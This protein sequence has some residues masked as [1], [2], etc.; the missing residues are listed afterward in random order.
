MRKCL[1]LV[2]FGLSAHLA[3]AQNSL[4]KQLDQAVEA[5]KRYQLIDA[6][7][8]FAE[9]YAQKQLLTNIQRGELLYYYSRAQYQ[10]YVSKGN[11]QKE[12]LADYQ[13][14]RQ[15]YF[16]HQLLLELQRLD[17]PR[18]SEKAEPQLRAMSPGLYEGALIS[19][20]LLFTHAEG[21]TPSTLRSVATGYLSLAETIDPV[22]Y[23]TH[24]LYGQLYYF[25]Q[26]SASA[27]FYFDRCLE[28][29]RTHRLNEETNMRLG[30][31]FLKRSRMLFNSSLHDTALTLVNHGLKM[32]A[33]EFQFAKAQA[34]KLFTK[35][36][37]QY[38]TDLYTELK[39]PLHWLKLELLSVMPEK[40]ATAQQVFD[41]L[42]T[43]YADDYRFHLYSGQMHEP[44]KPFE[45][46]KHYNA[47]VEINPKSFDA[48]Y[49]AGGLY[50]SLANDYRDMAQKKDDNQ[51]QYAKNALTLF[52]TGY[53]IMKQAHALNP[54]A[55]YVVTSLYHV[56][57]L[58][59]YPEDT[60]YFAKR[61][62]KE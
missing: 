45:A 52:R 38:A 17:V 46:L 11:D 50:F 23:Q 44:F 30:D 57:K 35:D 25:E 53:P 55:G 54:E 2:L 60:A 15:V 40:Y 36:E 19:L 47:A 9:L 8:S 31:V 18:W 32:M 28:L 34:G 39:K 27:A 51:K 62:P 42:Q 61:L 21:Y 37:V 4:D 13:M 49:L 24:E 5:F 56:A 12:A 43:T 3:N 48:C 10:M 7:S 14:Q 22:N 29:Y 59:N 1:W 20:D 6:N 41:S 26:D 16:A 33:F 58:L